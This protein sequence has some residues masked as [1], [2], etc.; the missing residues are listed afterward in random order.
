M[1]KRMITTRQTAVRKIAIRKIPITSGSTGVFFGNRTQTQQTQLS[2]QEYIKQKYASNPNYKIT[3]V[4][5][6]TVINSLSNNFIA[7][8]NNRGSKESS[9]IPETITINPNGTITK[10]NRSYF[11]AYNKRNSDGNRIKR[12][13]IYIKSIK[14]Y[15]SFGNL[16][17]ETINSPYTY[18]KKSYADGS[19]YTKK[20]I[21]TA[22]KKDYVKG[23]QTNLKI[24]GTKIQTQ[25]KTITPTKP[26]THNTGTFKTT[27]LKNLL[28]SPTKTNKVI[29]TAE[30]KL[31][32]LANPK[33]LI[34]SSYTKTPKEKSSEEKLLKIA[35]TKS[36]ITGSYSPTPTTQQKL[37]KITNPKN[38]ILGAYTLASSLKKKLTN[39]Q[40]KF[41]KNSYSNKK[42]DVKITDLNTSFLTKLNIKPSVQQKLIEGQTLTPSEY[43]DNQLKLQQLAV[44][45]GDAL[46]KKIINFPKGFAKGSLEIVKEFVTMMVDTIPNAYKFLNKYGYS[47]YE[48]SNTQDKTRL[49]IFLQDVLKA[50]KTTTQTTK[51]VNDHPREAA[52]IVGYAAYKLGANWLTDFYNDPGKTTGRAIT[53]IFGPGAT[54]KA[55][56]KLKMYS[57]IVIKN[58]KILDSFSERGLGQALKQLEGKKIDI[59]HVTTTKLKNLFKSTPITEK[60]L[61][62]LISD[63][64]KNPYLYL[65]ENGTLKSIKEITNSN[66]KKIIIDSIKDSKNVILGGSGSLKVQLKTFRKVGDIDV[67]AKLPK[68]TAVKVAKD[69]NNTIIGK[70]IPNRFKVFKNPYSLTYQIYDTMQPGYTILKQQRKILELIKKSKTIGL[71]SQSK[72]KLNEL[73]KKLSKYIVMDIADLT[74]WEKK[75]GKAKYKMIDGI[76]VLDVK[77][78]LL[79]KVKL[80]QDPT[81][82]KRR[83][84]ELK[85]INL[86]LGKKINVGRFGLI[87]KIF[88]KYNLLKVEAFGKLSGTA[89]RFDWAQ[90]YLGNLNLKFGRN[91]KVEKK[92]I[93]R[94]KDE[95]G[96]TDKQIVDKIKKYTPTDIYFAP[97]QI[98]TSYILDGGKKAIL[99][100]KNI[101]IS[102]YGKEIQSL[103]KKHYAG[104]TTSQEKGKLFR[105]MREYRLKN[106]NKVFVGQKA[107]ADKIG[108]F[109]VLVSEFSKFY[110]KKTLF[111]REVYIPVLNKFVRV[112][113]VF[114]GKLPPSKL[115]T[116]YNKFKRKMKK[117]YTLTEMKKDILVYANKNKIS[118]KKKIKSVNRNEKGHF[119]IC[120]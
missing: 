35:N 57:P 47:I 93:K 44:K 18:K 100:G 14:N 38:N 95:W 53:S 54:F 103:L 11:Q 8:Q 79:V 4:N 72:K 86:I 106:P 31:L 25:Q 88:E 23:I 62:F 83:A 111:N 115:R 48:R 89:R 7:S 119:S 28:F 45:S 46:L 117:G 105:L 104:L 2:T 6:A 65:K 107:L 10:V 22:I 63:I 70:L 76:K 61:K 5:G 97:N 118:L 21:T 110:P 30:E 90:E 24:P 67:M 40:I 108:E 82:L 85:D 12:N 33:G 112:Q 69:L 109:E 36:W 78:A 98:Y 60:Q 3:N 80:S 51:F 43:S 66:T 91:P 1:V 58:V 64:K 34:T 99:M 56:T 74:S 49:N 50:N 94:L 75:F 55:G 15:S 120:K 52:I 13:D 114:L 96:F 41:I 59:Y 26:I 42:T 16:L 19:S 73:Q 9:F 29:S 68:T 84:K 37:L 113:E 116:L 92:I 87:E 81:L 39:K 71:T 101:K 20:R 102:S 27:T 77:Q 17:S 32:K